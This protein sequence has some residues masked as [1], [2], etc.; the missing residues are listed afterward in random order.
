MWK[1]EFKAKKSKC[2]SERRRQDF[3]MVE[4]YLNIV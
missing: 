1:F 2:S 4:F 3:A